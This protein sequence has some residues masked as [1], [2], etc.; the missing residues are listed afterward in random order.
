MSGEHELPTASVVRS[1]QATPARR[2]GQLCTDVRPAGL[3]LSKPVPCSD[4]RSHLSDR[5]LRLVRLYIEGGLLVTAL[6]LVPAMLD[7]L[8]VPDNMT[9]R[10]SSAAAAL[11]F[12]VLL[13]IQFR[14]RRAIEPGGFPLWLVIIYTV[15]TLAV[16]SLWFNVAGIL[17]P[18]NAG[19]YAIVLTWALCVFGFTFV[20]TIELFLHGEV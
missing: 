20:R 19:V 12:T 14:R 15:A 6:A 1:S 17:Y 5:H 4:N 7:L 13:R 16:A 8:H 10:L 18:P 3:H 9:W 2:R 11:T